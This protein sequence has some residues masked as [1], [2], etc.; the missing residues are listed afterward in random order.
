M[1]FGG[2]SNHYNV[3]QVIYASENPSNTISINNLNLA[4]ALHNPNGITINYLRSIS[5]NVKL[6]LLLRVCGG[7]YCTLRSGIFLE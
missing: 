4:G 5:F 3:V 6:V 2:P 7:H 1:L